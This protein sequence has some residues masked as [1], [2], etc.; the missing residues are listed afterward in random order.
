MT[1]KSVDA[2]EAEIAKR[3]ADPVFQARL[4][5]LAEL[6]KR[7]Q[8]TIDRFA[9]ELGLA[10]HLVAAA[11]VECFLELHPSATVRLDN[12]EHPEQGA[13]LFAGSPQAAADLVGDLVR[14]SPGLRVEVGLPPPAPSPEEIN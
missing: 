5:E 13:L 7:G 14:A 2:F 6:L 1:P 10:R 3:T 8:L 12:P 11:S 4:E 9:Q